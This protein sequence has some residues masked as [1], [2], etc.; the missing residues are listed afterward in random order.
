MPRPEDDTW[1]QS[2]NTCPMSSKRIL[3]I[4][5]AG[6]TRRV[7]PVPASAT[8]DPYYVE[9]HRGL[10]LILIVRPA[11]QWDVSCFEVPRYRAEISRHSCSPADCYYLDPAVQNS[12]TLTTP[13]PWFA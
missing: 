5:T 4:R 10:R 12:I 11:R 7:T 2:L 6:I 13:T 3:W 8:S 1:T 9:L